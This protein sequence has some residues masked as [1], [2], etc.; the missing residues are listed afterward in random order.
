VIAITKY[1]YDL[2]NNFSNDFF[3]GHVTS[4][5]DFTK[6]LNRLGESAIMREDEPDDIGAAFQ[7]FAVVTKELALLMKNLVSR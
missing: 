4:Q 7:K 1:D 3:S 6:A 5:M 2:F